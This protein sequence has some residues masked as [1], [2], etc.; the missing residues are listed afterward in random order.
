MTRRRVL[1]GLVGGAAIF[2]FALPFPVAIADA[3]AAS[4]TT[5]TAPSGDPSN[6]RLVLPGGK[7]C[8]EAPVGFYPCP[9][10][11]YWVLR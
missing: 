8:W 2:T 10:F 11:V 7:V 3:V 4:T 5:A 9:A 6:E 1:T